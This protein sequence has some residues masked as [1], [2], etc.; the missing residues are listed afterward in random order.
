MAKAQVKKDRPGSHRG[1]LG[2]CKKVFFFH[3]NA[4]GWSYALQVEYKTLMVQS[5]LRC[6]IQGKYLVETMT[7][8]EK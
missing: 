6:Q 1:F 4:Q 5:T 7:W 3:S 2:L 8:A